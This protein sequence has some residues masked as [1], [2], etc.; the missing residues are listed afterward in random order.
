MYDIIIIRRL[1]V[2]AIVIILQYRIG[3]D[4]VIIARVTDIQTIRITGNYVVMD[5]VVAGIKKTNAIPFI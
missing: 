4:I 3:L 5:G 2:Y 1:D